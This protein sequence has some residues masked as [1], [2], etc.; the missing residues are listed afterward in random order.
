MRAAIWRMASTA[1]DVDSCTAR[2]WLAMS[3]VALA[4]CT[5]SDFTSDATTAKPL[6]ASPARAA[7]MVALSASR[8][9][10]PA[11]LRISLTTSPI[12]CAPSARPADFAVGGARFVG[13]KADDV[14]GL[15]QLTADLADRSRQLVGGNRRGFHVA[16]AS[17]KGM[18]RALCP[19]RCLLGGAE[20]SSLA[21]ERI[22]VA[23][24]A[25][26]GQQLLDS[27]TERINGG[28][29]CR[30]P[31]FLVA[32]GQA[33]LLGM[34]LLG[35]VLMSGDPAAAR[36]GLILG[37]HDTTIACLY[38]VRLALALRHRIENFLHV[39]VDVAREQA[40]LFAVFDQPLERA[41]WFHDLGSEFV[42][43]E[44]ARVEQGDAAL[45]I[46]HVQALRHVI[47]RSG[48]PAIL[49]V[50]A[51]IEKAQHDKSC[52]AQAEKQC[53]L[54]GNCRWQDGSE[55]AGS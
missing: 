7:S 1:P 11:M 47:E 12:F 9:V 43:L 4:V 16:E 39:A 5:A 29:D 46:K 35:D 8:F 31:L 32:N 20:Q 49:P 14:G 55:H 27:R 36:Q 22:A 24:A 10:C 19:L 50:Q 38:V 25:D 17:L 28:V 15:R 18:H 51:T 41:T 44:I 30:A 48:K 52:E 45:R 40:G 2:I 6:P 53:G 13:R 26:G 21:V 54:A 37:E 33:L 34:A 3:S 42:H 23:L